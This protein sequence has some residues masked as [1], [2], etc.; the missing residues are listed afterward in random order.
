[1]NKE[2]I[3]IKALKDIGHA[4]GYDTEHL[5]AD[6]YAD[7]GLQTLLRMFYDLQCVAYEALDAT[8]NFPELYRSEYEWLKERLK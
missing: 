8:G 4:N 1:M 7:P 3:L 2:Q 5:G 6:N